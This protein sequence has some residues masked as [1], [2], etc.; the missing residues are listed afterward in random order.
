[1]YL[2]RNPL[3]AECDKA[4]EVVAATLVDHV[5]P[6]SQGGADHESNYQG[7]CATCHNRKTAKE[8]KKKSL[9]REKLAV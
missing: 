3:C 4:G 5:I 9:T 1:M 7:L 6:L 2:V 8:R